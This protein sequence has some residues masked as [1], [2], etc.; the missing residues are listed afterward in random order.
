MNGTNLTS[1]N[2]K[3]WQKTMPVRKKHAP[4]R[5][6]VACRQV[7]DKRELIRVVRTP[8]NTVI[9]DPRGKSAGRGAYIC[10]DHTCWNAALERGSL[11]R[12]LKTEIADRDLMALQTF[13][14]SIANV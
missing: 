13:A 11:A 2:S 7:K 1:L 4:Q 5:T 6:C 8:E 12:A 14:A 9:I 3:Y 10:R